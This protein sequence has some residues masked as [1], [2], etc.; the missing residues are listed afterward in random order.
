MAFNYNSPTR[1]GS[2]EYEEKP[3]HGI[4]RFGLHGIAGEM[5]RDGPDPV[6][7][8]ILEQV[9]FFP[10][11]I[12]TT[13]KKTGF[14]LRPQESLLPKTASSKYGGSTTSS[15]GLAGINFCPLVSSSL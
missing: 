10:R 11:E 7:V 8:Q 2:P 13:T 14:D 9:N 3:A 6:T 5:V 12:E 1:K 4:N 15:L